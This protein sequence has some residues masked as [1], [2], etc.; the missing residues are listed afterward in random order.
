MNWRRSLGRYSS[1][2]EYGYGVNLLRIMNPLPLIG[3]NY[4][5]IYINFSL[6]SVTTPRAIFC[7]M[8]NAPA[9][10]SEVY[11]GPLL[12]DWKGGDSIRPEFCRLGWSLN[13]AY[14][15]FLIAGLNAH[16]LTN[17]SFCFLSQPPRKYFHKTTETS[18]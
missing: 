9:H 3:K 1:F 4:W 10:V 16:I 5:P 15:F 17:F 13:N 18:F 6:Y 12:K 8:E 2:A 11:Y 7:G 14:V